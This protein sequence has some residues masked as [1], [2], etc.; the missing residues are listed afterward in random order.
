MASQVGVTACD[1]QPDLPSSIVNAVI[2]YL[3]GA[4]HLACYWRHPQYLQL[5][6]SI[7]CWI[8]RAGSLRTQSPGRYPP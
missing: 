1:D 6:P 4:E 8:R 5:S 7:S 3:Q 2:S